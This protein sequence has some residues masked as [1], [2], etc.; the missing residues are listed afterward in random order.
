MFG[1]LILSPYSPGRRAANEA[2]TSVRIGIGNYRGGALVADRGSKRRFDDPILLPR[3]HQ[4]IR[5]PQ[6]AARARAVPFGRPLILRGKTRTALTG[7]GP[8]RLSEK[9]SQDFAPSLEPASLKAS[10]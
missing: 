3:G 5:R 7:V 2:P 1:C 8:P 6:C 10:M 9:A 4:Q